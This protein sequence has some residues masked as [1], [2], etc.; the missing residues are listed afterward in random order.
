MELTSS[1]C[2]ILI[3]AMKNLKELC[4]NF[5]KNSG[6]KINPE[7]K[8]KWDAIING[9]IN[10]CA[11]WKGKHGRILYHDN[12]FYNLDEIEKKF[13]EVCMDVV[14]LGFRHSG[15]DFV[16]RLPHYEDIEIEPLFR[17]VWSDYNIKNFIPLMK[18]LTDIL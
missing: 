8:K 11:V 5:Y 3:N 1:L 2:Q 13:A 9:T 7:V 16:I 17:T 18:T 10:D 6:A 4:E 12:Y 15:G 14:D